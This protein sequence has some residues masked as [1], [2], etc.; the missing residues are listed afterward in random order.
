MSQSKG[1]GELLNMT[2]V[3]GQADRFLF[4]GETENWGKLH[5]FVLLPKSQFYLIIL[6]FFSHM[7]LKQNTYL[8]QVHAK[9][10][11]T[12][13]GTRFGK[14]KNVSAEEKHPGLVKALKIGK[15]PLNYWKQKACTVIHSA[16][17]FDDSI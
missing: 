8:A 9:I 15:T 14:G 5:A 11:I 2:A 13:S 10:P 16:V 17:P 4:G 7:V 1:F 6:E 12:K 3:V